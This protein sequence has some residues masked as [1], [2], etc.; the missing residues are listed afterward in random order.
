MGNTQSFKYYKLA[1]HSTYIKDVYYA[2]G[3]LI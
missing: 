2:N 1:F 3:A